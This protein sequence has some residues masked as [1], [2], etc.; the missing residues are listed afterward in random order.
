MS[1]EQIIELDN[2]TLDDCLDLY[3]KRNMITIINDGR[4]VNFL[5]EDKYED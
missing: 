2:V 4:I 5:K 3:I 1:Y